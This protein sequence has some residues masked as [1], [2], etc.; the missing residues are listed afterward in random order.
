MQIKPKKISGKEM[1]GSFFPV[2][3]CSVERYGGL[4]K[5]RT[6]LL[7]ASHFLRRTQ[8]MNFP[9][10]TLHRREPQQTGKPTGITGAD[11]SDFISD[12]HK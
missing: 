1:T 10:S 12:C 8:V 2:R 9:N 6:C 5:E 4:A 7:A 3:V 11:A